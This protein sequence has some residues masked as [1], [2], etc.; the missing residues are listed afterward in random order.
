MGLFIA[1]NRTPN[2]DC[3]WEGAVPKGL[4]TSA[5]AKGTSPRACP[6]EGW[7]SLEG[8][9][10]QAWQFALDMVSGL[11]CRFGVSEFRV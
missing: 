7:V 2:I 1:L 5:G 4:Q 8:L 3:Y 10:S 9:G 11:G 6:H